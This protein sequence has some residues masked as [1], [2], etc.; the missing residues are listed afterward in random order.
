M[1]SIIS[2]FQLK[3]QSLSKYVISLDAHDL[4]L[5]NNRYQVL[6]KKFI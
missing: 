1:K 3:Q 5:K 6:E 4:V 2:A